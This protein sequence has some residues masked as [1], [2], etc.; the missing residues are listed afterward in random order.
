M[1]VRSFGSQVAHLFTPKTQ[2]ELER[3]RGHLV[4]L[5]LVA[6]I[7]SAKHVTGLT[8]GSAQYTVYGLTIALA[9]IV[10]GLAPAAVATMAAVLLTNADA[11]ASALSLGQMLFA[12]EGLGL[13]VVVGSIVRR[14]RETSARLEAAERANHALTEEVRRA[15]I[16]H[17][18]FEHLGEA[19]AD[20]AAFVVNAHGLIVEWPRSA[21]RLY[22]FTDAQMLGSD[23]SAVLEE[24]WRPSGLDEL[25]AEGDRQEPVR[26]T[27]VHRRADGTPLHAE[28]TIRRCGLH[29]REHFTVAVEDLARRRETDAFREAA[30]RA[31]TA[32]QRAA[33]EARAQL[34][35]LEALTDPA[36]S[37]VAGSTGVDELL[38]RLRASLRAEGV[39]LVRIGRTSTRIVAS[40]GLRPA[41][42]GKSGGPMSTGTGDSRVALVHNDA[43]RVAQ[44]SAL[45][46]PPTVS[47]LLVV[48]V[49]H[50][51][52]M[53]FRLEV[54]NERR[55]PATEW[56]LALA[57]IVA[58][59]LASARLLHTP[60]DSA[61]AVA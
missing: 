9:A 8:D 30:L 42:V 4:A 54:V 20:T 52:P 45:Q 10:G 51:G 38:D 41:G 11:P 57:R 14:R 25:P 5:L 2:D 53:A 7:W 31:Q 34:E 35:T 46:W 61:D 13:T 12:L 40:A 17:D 32:L 19:A 26:R 15:R 22:G 37:V 59:R 58:D 43:A 36:V 33:D 23:V 49:R 56:D 60:V 48:P 55:A 50:A 18:A 44:V 3:R 47:S 39:A 24:S 28:F 6:V 27:G 16:S 1:S 29:D 21:A